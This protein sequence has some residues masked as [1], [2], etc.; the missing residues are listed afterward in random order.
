MSMDDLISR[1]AA[2]RW[3]KTECNPYGKPTLDFESGKKVIEHLE[4][5]PSAQ[6]EEFEWCT[7]CKEY[8]QERHCCPRWTKVIRNTVEELKKQAQWI[9]CSER[10]PEAGEVVLVYGK[11]GGI[12]TAVYNKPGTDW[13]NGWWKLNSKSHKCMPDAWMPLPEPYEVEE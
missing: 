2:I 13:R 7:D 4:Q 10:L 12:Y 6:P 3:V 11:R 5:M 1:Q 8:D 9:P